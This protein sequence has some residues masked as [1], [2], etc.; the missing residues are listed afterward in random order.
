MAAFAALATGCYTL[1]KHPRPVEL[2]YRRPPADRPCSDCH[3]PDELSSFLKPQHL[4]PAA[5]PWAELERPWW[6]S[7]AKADS[8]GG[9][10][11]TP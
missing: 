8:S 10:D 2:G 5:H 6:E 7:G 4:Q 9:D 11:A 3:Q 1:L